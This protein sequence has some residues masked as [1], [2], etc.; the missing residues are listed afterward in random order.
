MMHVLPS[1]AA[2]APR[3]FAIFFNPLATRAASVNTSL[4][5]YYAN[6]A[7]GPAPVRVQWS[8][9]DVEQATQDAAFSVRLSRVV[10]PRGYDFA[11]LS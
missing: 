4:C 10:P 9:G 8:N 7:A 3:A 6:F 11:I 2:G 1:A 5:V